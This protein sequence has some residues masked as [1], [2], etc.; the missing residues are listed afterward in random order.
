[1]A[2]VVMSPA[3]PRS[4]RSAWRTIGSTRRVGRG[5]SGIVQARFGTDVGRDRG[6]LGKRLIE[7]DPRA[8]GL[9]WPLGEI[10]AAV[11]AD[12]VPRAAARRRRSSAQPRPDRRPARPS[13]RARPK[14]R[15]R[16]A[17]RRPS[18]MTPAACDRIGRTAAGSGAGGTARLRSG[19][20]GRDGAP[21]IDR[22]T[23]AAKTAASVSELL[24]SRLAPC[25]PVHAASP[26]AQSPATELRPSASTAIPPM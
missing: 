15:P 20:G 7:R 17:R 10:E 13:A 14:A 11:R 6:G 24:A 25:S 18:R 9:R 2:S 5:D 21:S 1:M 26:Q 8:A 23:I 12:A 16:R 22:A 19:A 4:S 3:R